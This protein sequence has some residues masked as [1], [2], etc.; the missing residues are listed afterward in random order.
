[1]GGCPSPGANENPTD[2][3]A[4]T[5]LQER[6]KLD[7]SECFAEVKREGPGLFPDATPKP[8]LETPMHQPCS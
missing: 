8:P 5:I 2:P 6:F 4:F 7:Q 3:G 1:M